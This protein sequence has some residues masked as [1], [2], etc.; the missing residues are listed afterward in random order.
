MKRRKDTVY[1]RSNYAQ[2]KVINVLN[3][4]Y[5]CVSLRYISHTSALD[6]S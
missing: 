3:M 6:Q 4:R 1:N 5:P 2:Y